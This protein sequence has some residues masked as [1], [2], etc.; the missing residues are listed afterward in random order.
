[1]RVDDPAQT[2]LPYC[3]GDQLNRLR[4]V[5][6]IARVDDSRATLRLVICPRKNYV[7]RRQPTALKNSGANRS[8]GAFNRSAGLQLEV[9][10]SRRSILPTFVLGSSSR[11]F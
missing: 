5:R 9:L 11:I 6:V 4:T 1:M 3:C 2:L 8:E 10:N 7:V